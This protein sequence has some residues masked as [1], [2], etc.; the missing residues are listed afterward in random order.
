MSENYPSWYKFE[1][2][3]I[4][5]D[6][7]VEAGESFAAKTVVGE[8]ANV[9]TIKAY[10]SRTRKPSA[11]A[12][13]AQE[14]VIIRN[15]EV[16]KR[17]TPRKRQ[18]VTPDIHNT[19]EK[20]FNLLS[21]ERI[22][23]S[24]ILHLTGDNLM[25]DES[26]QESLLDSQNVYD[27]WRMRESVA[28]SSKSNH[29]LNSSSSPKMTASTSKANSTKAGGSSK[30]GKAKASKVKD[31]KAKKTKTTKTKTKTASA[32]TKNN[33]AK[34][35]TATTKI[36]VTT[37]KAKSKKPDDENK[38]K[39]CM[40]KTVDK[41]LKEM[42]IDVKRVSWCVKAGMCKGYIKLTGD[43]SDL[44]QLIIKGSLDDHMYTVALKDVLYQSDYGGDYEDGSHD[45]TAM[46]D[47]C[48]EET[49]YRYKAYVT[50]ICQGQPELN[51]GK[52]HNHCHQCKG[53]GQC[54]GDYREAHCKKCKK[55]YFAGLQGFKCDNCQRNRDGGGRGNN[56]CTIS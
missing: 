16:L 42:G 46:C 18:K 44:D 28:G 1:S 21:D 36:K 24:P 37:S 14:S 52:Y 31:R 56:G 29:S 45:A 25:V 55:H 23:L 20:T 3:K 9:E 11:K 53:F 41:R 4:K 12:I 8:T 51:D 38:R 34:A 39:R 30:V 22:V 43:Q 26:S 47:C 7:E 15:D 17:K 19:P 33:T 40:P 27:T 54:I 6:F 35:K 49:D 13:A 32:T 50:R 48:T 5:I 10:P 2:K